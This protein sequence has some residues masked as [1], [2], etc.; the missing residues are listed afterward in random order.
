MHETLES[1]SL[2]SQM[3]FPSV[4]GRGRKCGGEK[5]SGVFRPFSVTM[6]NAIIGRVKR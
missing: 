2:T 4:D 3:P 5:G 1:A 6:W